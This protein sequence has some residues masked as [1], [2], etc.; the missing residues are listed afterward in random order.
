MAMSKKCS[1]CLEEF[2]KEE[3]LQPLSC[4]HVFHPVCIRTWLQ[5]KNECPYCRT[6]QE[7]RYV[8]VDD[9]EDVG[10]DEYLGPSP[11]ER[12]QARIFRE[13]RRRM[14]ETE[15]S[16]YTNLAMLG[17]VGLST[18]I[19]S[20]CR[21]RLRSNPDSVVPDLNGWTDHLLANRDRIQPIVESI[22]ESYME[23]S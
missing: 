12:E 8:L 14:R 10:A 11:E 18:L 22:V 23:N 16:S 7:R 17:I 9:D 4:G 21:G 13:A 1:I 3:E 2:K 6:S 5:I 20:F 15:T 19:E